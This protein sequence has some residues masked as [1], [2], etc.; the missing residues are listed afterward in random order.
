MRWIYDHHDWQMNDALGSC[1][2]CGN[3]VYSKA[4]TGHMRH[5]KGGTEAIEGQENQK[6]E[7]RL[8]SQVAGRQENQ[9]TIESSNQTTSQNADVSGGGDYPITRRSGE[10]LRLWRLRE[11]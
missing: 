1:D 3:L 10:M 4:F 7:E 2:S 8:G 5:C 6:A 11:K 9:S